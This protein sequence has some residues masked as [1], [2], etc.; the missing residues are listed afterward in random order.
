MQPLKKNLRE[1]IFFLSR[2]FSKI[3]LVLPS[4]SVERVG[5]SRMRD[6]LQKGWKV[7]KLTSRYK[8][9]EKKG[10]WGF[11]YT[12]VGC[13]RID[14]EGK[15]DA[16]VTEGYLDQSQEDWDVLCSEDLYLD[17]NSFRTKVKQPTGARS[18]WTLIGK[19]TACHIRCIV[20]YECER[21]YLQEQV[22][23]KCMHNKL[24][25]HSIATK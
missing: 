24:I 18:R 20:I 5:V 4:A 1:L 14:K 2:N 17:I 16:G 22:P 25:T 8:E 19:C 12:S 9:R 6:F 7:A 15:Q 10:M 13:S 21:R 11:H 3:V 23:F